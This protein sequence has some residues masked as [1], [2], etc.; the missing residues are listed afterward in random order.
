MRKTFR[1]YLAAGLLGGF[2]CLSAF[3]ARAKQQDVV[4]Q[5]DQAQQPEA[6]VQ[7]ESPID[8]EANPQIFSVM[9]ALDAAGFD[10][11]ESALG[12]MPQQMAL[13][14]AL[15]KMN[16][17]AAEAVREFYRQHELADPA[18]VLSRYIS[19]ALV[20][21]PPPAFEFQGDQQTL[22][23]DVLGIQG[24]Q[25]LLANF[26]QAAHLYVRWQEIKPEYEATIAPYRTALTQIVTVSNAYLREI[27]KPGGGTFR[28]YVEPTVGSRINFRNYG[29]EYA[30]VVG[31][32][33]DSSVEAIRY[34]FLHFMLDPMVLRDQAGILKKEALLQVAARA[35]ELPAEYQND[36]VSLF[37]ECLVRAVDMRVRNLP[38]NQVETELAKDDASGFILVRPLAAELKLFEKSEPAMS[39]YFPDLVNGIDVVGEE[40]RLQNYKFANGPAQQAEGLGFSQDTRAAELDRLLA[41]GDRE[42][43]QQNAAAATGTF[44][45]VVARY[46]T[47]ARGLYGL[48][49]ASV[50]SG[51]AD[52][53]KELFEKIVALSKN[54][55]SAIGAGVSAQHPEILAWSYVY[56]GRISDLEDDRENALT[57]YRAAQAVDGAPAD[58]RIAAANGVEAPYAP[59]T[60]SGGKN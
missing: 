27:V 20:V 22:P 44:G 40:A 8:V 38:A 6:P 55:Q 18:Q 49:I 51:K 45:Q 19:L 5:P 30:V 43:A 33:T 56:L 47:D 32:K 36:F 41:E 48:A 50:L 29:A 13:Q 28:V 9:C 14:A 42:I 35:P 54:G 24:F 7:S 60:A 52:R 21:G 3:A 46:P 31:P 59:P 57:E 15:Q 1:R 10:I 58:A 4:Q 11:D 53:A 25:P 34:A 37:D 2:V 23:P 16:D 17:P 26:Y 39:Y 12:E